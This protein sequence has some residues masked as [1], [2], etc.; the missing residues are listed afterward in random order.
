MEAYCW[1]LLVGSW[2]TF[3]QFPQSGLMTGLGWHISKPCGPNLD[4]RNTGVNW[5]PS[6]LRH[7]SDHLWALGHFPDFDLWP[8]F[9]NQQ[10]HCGLRWSVLDQS[11]HY[12]NWVN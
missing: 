3:P 7:C 1:L 12:G 9:C 11:S 6:W 5:G 10:K 4:I 2:A 8:L